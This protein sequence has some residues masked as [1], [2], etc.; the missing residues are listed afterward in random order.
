MKAIASY[1][2]GKSSF[3]TP[4]RTWVRL[5]FLS[6]G[7]KRIQNSHRKHFFQSL[8]PFAPTV[9][10]GTLLFGLMLR[11]EWLAK[12]LGSHG[13]YRELTLSE[14]WALEDEEYLSAKED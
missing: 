12:W 1:V 9:L 10:E 2:Y 6:S 4:L 14:L 5:M 3:P 13:I 8:E 7:T 11:Y